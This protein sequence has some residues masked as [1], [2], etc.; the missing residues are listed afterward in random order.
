[1]TLSMFS[2]EIKSALSS[3]KIAISISLSLK[4]ESDE[5][6]SVNSG[7]IFD[8]GSNPKVQQTISYRNYILSFSA[9]FMKDNYGLIF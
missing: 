7:P 4:N 6:T 5:K 1:M 8:P 9:F 3:D 2:E